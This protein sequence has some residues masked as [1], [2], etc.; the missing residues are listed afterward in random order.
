MDLFLKVFPDRN[1]ALSEMYRDSNGSAPRFLSGISDELN[2]ILDLNLLSNDSDSL[3][4]G[5]RTVTTT[6]ETMKSPRSNVIPLSYFL[7]AI[8]ENAQKSSP[9]A[10]S[11]FS[12]SARLASKR[13]ESASVVLL[14]LRQ[15]AV[16]NVLLP[17]A[18]DPLR[19]QSDNSA[20]MGGTNAEADENLIRE[21]FALLTQQ[22]ALYTVETLVL[23]ARA[24]Q[25]Q[26]RLQFHVLGALVKL[27]FCKSGEDGNDTMHGSKWMVAVV[28]YAESVN[29]VIE[30]ARNLAGSSRARLNEVDISGRHLEFW[31]K[32]VL[33]IAARIEQLCEVLIT[34]LADNRALQSDAQLMSKFSRSVSR[35]VRRQS[36][37]ALSPR[38]ESESSTRN[39][40]GS[41]AFE[42][43]SRSMSR[44]A[45]LIDLANNVLSAQD[46]DEGKETGKKS[47]RNSELITK[48]PSKT[49]SRLGSIHRH[50][51]RSMRSNEI[52]PK[53]PESG[54]GSNTATPPVSASENRNTSSEKSERK[55][56]KSK[57]TKG[58]SLKIRNL[59]IRSMTEVSRSASTRH[60]SHSADSPQN[61]T[62]ADS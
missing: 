4:I 49:V 2:S 35:I 31:K 34:R 5:H 22:D 61:R 37:V 60:E 46:G 47:K 1:E 50:S 54:S 36:L 15:I 14:L 45:S 42:P 21:S 62:L 20:Q 13:E 7:Q 40:R 55:H 52:P 59:K 19:I 8:P 56:W 44:A 9:H 32:D 26:L 48:L 11:Y 25:K 3:L 57:P 27:S 43:R 38:S 6:K 33:L 29:R 58:I 16:L 41:R 18:E 53:P 28:K 12:I 17:E 23:V 51:S 39:G 24:C 30:S 10:P